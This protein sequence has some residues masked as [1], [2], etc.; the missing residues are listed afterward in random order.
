M[1][2][3]DNLNV[4]L[5]ACPRAFNDGR[6]WITSFQLPSYSPDLNPVEG[7]WFLVRR[8]GQC[9]TAFTAPST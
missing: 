1:V 7:I 3:W 9:N 5:D 8:S 6:V 4:H 2:V